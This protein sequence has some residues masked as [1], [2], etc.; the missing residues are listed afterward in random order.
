M[1]LILVLRRLYS[2]TG[3]TVYGEVWLSTLSEKSR[4]WMYTSIM[5][6]SVTRHVCL[7]QLYIPRASTL[8]I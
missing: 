3:S 7:L 5:P 6:V 8:N 2:Y 4:S 1:Q